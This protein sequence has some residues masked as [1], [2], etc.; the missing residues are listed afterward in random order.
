MLKLEKRADR[1]G[2]TGWYLR[3]DSGV[4]VAQIYQTGDSA[5]PDDVLPTPQEAE[6]WAQRIIA[7]LTPPPPSQDD[8][9]LV[10]AVSNAAM[11]YARIPDDGRSKRLDDAETAL[12]AALAAV[13]KGVLGHE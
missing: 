13:T 2:R 12:L 3:D 1:H 8:V 10:K 6:A 7:A 11:S 5:E 4:W 9:A